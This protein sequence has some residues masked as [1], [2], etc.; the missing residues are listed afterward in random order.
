MTAKVRS[1]R[2]SFSWRLISKTVKSRVSPRDIKT[3]GRQTRCLSFLPDGVQS[4]VGF[5]IGN[6]QRLLLRT[7][8]RKP[9]DNWRPWRFKLKS[10][11]TLWDRTQTW[12]P[13]LFP[14]AG[15]EPSGWYF[16]GNKLLL[17]SLHRSIHPLRQSV[18]VAVMSRT[19]SDIQS[20]ARRYICYKNHII[21]RHRG[22][23]FT[24]LS[25]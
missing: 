11:L 17:L 22:M 10:T 16:S 12:I 1:N 2:F 5:D 9:V 8:S 4:S 24:S 20:R 19:H 14:L 23:A 21:K 15:R 6:T 7:L 3:T 25:C 18:L 13:F